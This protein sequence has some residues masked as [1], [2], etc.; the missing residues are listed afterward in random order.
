MDTCPECGNRTLVA[1]RIAGVTVRECGMCGERV[2]DR[3]ALDDLG[4]REE[5]DRRGI[6]FELWPLVVA[7]ES[8]LGLAVEAAS[9]PE[10]TPQ[11]GE[12]FVATPAGSP[13]ATV[14]IENLLRSI[15][16][17]GA[18]LVHEWV[19]E[20]RHERHLQYVLRP[21]RRGAPVDLRQAGLD[22][23]EL[24]SQLARNARLSW[25]HDR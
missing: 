8:E 4:A 16:L 22:A 12:L 6:L 10:V 14:Q 15:Q 25:W 24:A 17:A 20:L 19:V 11:D 2:A 5:A 7:V 23:V 1:R 18:T 3:R 13:G 9:P 21:R